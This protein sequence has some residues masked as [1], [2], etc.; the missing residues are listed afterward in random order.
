MP[1]MIA[2]YGKNFFR[3]QTNFTLAGVERN[4]LGLPLRLPAR[5]VAPRKEQ[6]RGREQTTRQLRAGN[7]DIVA[8][9]ITQG[10]QVRNVSQQRHAETAR[11]LGRDSVVVFR[12]GR[13]QFSRP[14]QDQ[15]QGAQ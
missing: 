5:R 7:G 15:P 8:P 3:R 14:R 4:S 9:G 6:F 2:I 13:F 1:Q 10:G 12:D 11:V